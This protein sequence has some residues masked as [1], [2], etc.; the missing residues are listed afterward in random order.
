MTQI[1]LLAF[2]R[3]TRTKPIRDSARIATP[4]APAYSSPPARRTA[5]NDPSIAV[6]TFFNVVHGH[7]RVVGVRD[8]GDEGGA[9]ALTN[10]P[11]PL[12]TSFDYLPGRRNDK[13]CLATTRPCG[14]NRHALSVI[15]PR[16]R[17]VGPAACSAVDPI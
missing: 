7:C 8:A 5:S 13:S 17:T 2:G 11:A 1:S 10:R 15:R 12:R 3:E 6:R 9:E 14:V 4:L 16:R